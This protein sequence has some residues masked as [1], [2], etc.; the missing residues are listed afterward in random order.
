MDEKINVLNVDSDL[1]SE[2]N[3]LLLDDNDIDNYIHQK[4]FERHGKFKFSIFNSGRH[5]L[6][7]LKLTKIKYHYVM[8]DVYMPDMD[9]FTFIQNFNE[10]LNTA[11]HGQV[12][13][14]SA[15]L[16]PMVR[17]KSATLGLKFIEK[18]F[19]IEKIVS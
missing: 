19:R 10:H 5:A 6:E 15:S 13:I 9:G 2:A 3:V 11:G 17:I 7:H 16:N 8:V 1:G 12:V 4:N 18:P 14:L